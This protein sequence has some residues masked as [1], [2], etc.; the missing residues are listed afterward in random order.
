MQAHRPRKTLVPEPS[1]ASLEEQ[2]HHAHQH[3]ALFADVFD[4]QA[5][6]PDYVQCG[7][8]SSATCIALAALS[9]QEA[10]KVRKLLD[11][12]PASLKNWSAGPSAGAPRHGARR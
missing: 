5:V 9:R 1:R 6:A 12:M 4:L 7:S 8:L 10:A 3:F 11:E 2:L